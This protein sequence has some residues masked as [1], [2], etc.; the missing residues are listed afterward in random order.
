MLFTS[1]ISLMETLEIGPR[2]KTVDQRTDVLARA[3]TT[4]FVDAALDTESL[5][6]R[7]HAKHNV[8]EG[9]HRIPN[10]HATQIGLERA[11]VPGDLVP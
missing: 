9:Y 1:Q 11:E 5:P 3:P 6:E 10:V 4:M 8:Y 7:H 2:F